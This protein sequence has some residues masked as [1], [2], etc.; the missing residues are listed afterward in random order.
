MKLY[1]RYFSIILRS[2]MQYKSS[3]L[4]MAIGHFLIPFSTFAGIYF[5]FDRFNNVEGFSFVEVLLCFAI[6]LFSFSFAECFVRGFDAFRG[7]IS[8]GE[9]DRIMVRPQN[10]MLQV[11]A[12]R[13]EFSR[14]TRLLQAVLV[15]GYAIPASGIDWTVDKIITLCLMVFGGICLFSGLFIVY[16][17][18]C[19]FTIEGLEFMNIFTDGGRE[20]GKYPLNIYGEGILKFFTYIVPLA[21]VQYYPLL[22]ILGRSDNILFAFL[23]LGGLVFMIPAY[24][25]WRFGIKHY[26]S[27]GS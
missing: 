25:F 24:I 8:N 2:Q 5:M 18:I 20:F 9:F 27:T 19:F 3:F 7:I 10:E 16:A 21:L 17:S 13:I 22:Y 11:L 15:F 23:P 4:M 12:S 6:V 1:M 14:I 26:K